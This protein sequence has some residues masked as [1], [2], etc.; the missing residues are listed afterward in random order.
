MQWG[1]IR[2]W[3][4]REVN[5]YASG[6]VDRVAHVRGDAAW[7]ESRLAH[8][9]TRFVALWRT[10][11]LVARN[12]E[13]VTPAW[14]DR[15]TVAA[16]L[17]DERAQLVL[18][19][20]RG[21]AAHFAVDL[22]HHDEPP[23]ATHGA[24]EDLRAFGALLGHGDGALLAYGRAML[25]WH[26]RHR[27]C[28]VCGH[29]TASAE[30]GHVRRCTNA[31][32]G[33]SHFPRTDPA[34]IMLVTDGDRVVMSRQKIWPVG[35][36]SVLAGFVEPG[37]S[38]EDAVRR[39]V[40]E[41]VGVALNEVVYRHSQPWP[42]PGSIMLGFRGY[43]EPGSELDVNLDELDAGFWCSR[44]ELRNSPENESFRLP[45]LDSIARRLIE[46]WLAEG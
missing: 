27:F 22:S 16:L 45:R 19:G 44:E 34:V 29:P 3:D 25:H 33:A 5:F 2:T 42:F 38:L 30:A 1:P 10:R 46:E 26:A 8:P 7:L 40:A 37:E 20:L 11:N 31:D 12:G 24:F 28:G 4:G 39:E 36:H 14:L 32:C 13:A 43:C 18:L 15:E 6:D 41:E 35:M 23:L 9:E 17:D 21:E